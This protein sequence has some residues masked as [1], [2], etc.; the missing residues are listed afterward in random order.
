MKTEYCF[1]DVVECNHAYVHCRNNGEEWSVKAN[2]YRLK[3]IFDQANDLANFYRRMADD[4]YIEYQNR[5]DAVDN[6]KTYSEEEIKAAANW[7][8]YGLTKQSEMRW[9]NDEV[10]EKRFKVSGFFDALD[11]AWKQRDKYTKLAQQA[12]SGLY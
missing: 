11:Y 1:F 3:E 9:H 5:H 8:K 2:E 10:K 4:L 7:R 12:K 6:L